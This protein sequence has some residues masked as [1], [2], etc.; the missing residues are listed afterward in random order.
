[1]IFYVVKLQLVKTLVVAK[2][3]QNI[4]Y[5]TAQFQLDY[6]TRVTNARLYTFFRL[7]DAYMRVHLRSMTYECS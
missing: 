3:K 7:L 1:M 2:T 4:M 5:S 6:Y